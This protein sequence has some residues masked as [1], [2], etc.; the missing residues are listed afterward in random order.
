MLETYGA[1]NMIM[2][3]EATWDKS[4][5]DQAN[6]FANMLRSDDLALKQMAAKRIIKAG[7]MEI[8]LLDTMQSQVL[9]VFKE[10]NKDKEFASTYA[11]LCKAMAAS[12]N[13]KYAATVFK[14]ADG[15]GNPILSNYAKRYIKSYALSRT[16]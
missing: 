15:A 8:Y 1:W 14:V 2:N 7:D 16:P 12:R 5:R 4:Q 6:R 13:G 3:D 11:Y 10:Q 9:A